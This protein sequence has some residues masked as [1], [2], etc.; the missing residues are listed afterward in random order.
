MNLIINGKVSIHITDK[1]NKT[2]VKNIDAKDYIGDFYCLYNIKTQFLYK[3][4]NETESYAITKIDLLE[5]L[6]KYKDLS[7]AF[8]IRSYN[9][10]KEQF[11]DF[12]ISK[13]QIVL[14]ENLNDENFVDMNSNVN[15][16][17]IDSVLKE[18]IEKINYKISEIKNDIEIMNSRLDETYTSLKN[19]Y[20]IFS[21]NTESQIDELILN[22][23]NIQEKIIN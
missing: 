12:M 1:E 2:Y 16:F 14:F 8:R 20:N 23:K 4:E 10:Y 3:S 5:G 15:G 13:N 22:L 7:N 6:H 17:N 11:Y 21:N 9:R 19:E 18:N